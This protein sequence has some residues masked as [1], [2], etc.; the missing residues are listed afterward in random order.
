[1][2]MSDEHVASSEQQMTSSVVQFENDDVKT[3][4]GDNTNAETGPKNAGDVAVH[5]MGKPTFLNGMHH[6]IFGSWV[7]ILLIMVPVALAS[8]AFHNELAQFFVCVVAIIPC[9]GL[10][11]H[12]TEELA[13]Y[14]SQAV[15]GILNATFGNAVELI[16]GIIALKDGLLRI[17]QAS[18]MGSILS[19]LLLV[20]GMSFVAAG[21]KEK[22]S[23]FSAAAAQTAA[24]LLLLSIMGMIIPAAL[25]E[26]G[27]SGEPAEAEVI[28]HV[29][30]MHRRAIHEESKVLALS[31]FTAIILLGVYFFYLWFQ[32][33]SHA[34]LYADEEHTGGEEA[35]EPTLPMWGAGVLLLGVTVIVAIICEFMIGA[36]EHVVTQ[37]HISE[38][39][40]GVIILPIVG[41][42]AEHST[43]VT[44]ALKG[45]MNLAI[46]VAV[47][48]SLQ[49][50]LMVMPVLVLIGWGIGQPLS[51]NFEGFE[52]A[53]GLMTVII[54]CAVI[55]EGEST[56]L[57]GVMLIATYIILAAAFWYGGETVN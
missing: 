15:G 33:V 18:V 37:A 41:N 14:T 35:E 47:G 42:A 57:E 1:M 54:V 16:L 21:F 12:A 11:G 20:L 53:C 40:I 32:L 56:Y 6:A 2:D 50:C 43:A 38:I 39:F 51:F 27:I 13:L 7:N 45:K 30:A 25:F 8:P 19:N 5:H 3:S 29:D 31:R 26:F 9:A 22:Q 17:V 28:A 24:S 44:S 49:I 36:I 4:N 52:T 23:K 34:H 48:S 55:Q 10:M 46:G